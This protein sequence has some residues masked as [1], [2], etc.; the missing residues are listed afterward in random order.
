MW[1][2]LGRSVRESL[3][4]VESVGLA[5]DL[6]S[7]AAAPAPGQEEAASLLRQAARLRDEALS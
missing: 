5:L 2:S 3:G 6:A 1:R 7:G 4:G